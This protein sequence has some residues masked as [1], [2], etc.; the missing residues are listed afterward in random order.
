VFAPKCRVQT[1]IARVISVS[2]CPEATTCPEIATK[3]FGQLRSRSGEG[4]S[5]CGHVPCGADPG[6]LDTRPA[7]KGS[8]TRSSCADVEG[9]M[10]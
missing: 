8:V 9:A 6:G 5:N 7:V 4:L 2:D 3:F 10:C 1:C